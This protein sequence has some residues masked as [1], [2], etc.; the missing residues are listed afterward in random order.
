MTPRS[1][2]ELQSSGL[3]WLINTTVFWP[4]GYSLCLLIE[5]DG[6][7]TGWDL[8]GDG[9]EPWQHSDNSMAPTLDDLF[10]RVQVT[11]TT[12]TDWELVEPDWRW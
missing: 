11:L 2:K 6:S 12:K 3:L 1:I 10:Q 9:S 5:D 4:R 7:C 8:L